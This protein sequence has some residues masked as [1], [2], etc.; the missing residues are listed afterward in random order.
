MKNEKLNNCLEVGMMVD[1]YDSESKSTFGAK[2][3]GQKLDGGGFPYFSLEI[4]GEKM[5]ITG[6]AEENCTPIYIDS[7]GFPF[8]DKLRIELEDKIVA[9][10]GS[11][12]PLSG[13]DGNIFG[14]S[15]EKLNFYDLKLTI[16]GFLAVIDSGKNPD[17]SEKYEIIAL[18][19]FVAKEY[20]GNRSE[21]VESLVYL[22]KNCTDEE[23][24]ELDINGSI[25]E[26]DEIFWDNNT[27][28]NEF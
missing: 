21:I 9:V 16:D 15:D 4:N 12:E 25:D 23:L 14:F 20:V 26:I 27:N 17:V 18:I 3:L 6:L 28:T 11:F 7:P 13:D 22:A 5:D 19:P 8:L 1:Y 2:F 10:T 24:K